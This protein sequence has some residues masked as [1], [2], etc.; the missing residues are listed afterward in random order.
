MKGIKDFLSYV[1]RYWTHYPVLEIAKDS[2]LIVPGRRYYVTMFIILDD[3]VMRVGNV[4]V[5]NTTQE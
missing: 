2:P 1:R 5:A 4:N 3:G